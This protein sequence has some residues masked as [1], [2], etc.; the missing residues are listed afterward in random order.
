MAYKRELPQELEE[1]HL[2]FHEFMLQKCLSDP[3]CITP[4]I[5]IQVTEDLSYEEILMAIQ[6]HQVCKLRTKYVASIK[7]LWRNNDEE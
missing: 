2:I 4:I 7:V 6:D 5:D 3:S 1:V